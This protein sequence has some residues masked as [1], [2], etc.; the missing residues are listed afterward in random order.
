M[1]TYVCFNSTTLL[2][3][4]KTDSS[5]PSQHPYRHVS[6][7][8][9]QAQSRQASR[10]SQQKRELQVGGSS[11]YTALGTPAH[12]QTLSWSKRTCFASQATDAHTR[13]HAH[14]S[15]HSTLHRRLCSSRCRC[16]QDTHA[17]AP[18]S[19]H[20]AHCALQPPKSQR[21]GGVAVW[22]CRHRP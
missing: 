14:M 5:N 15:T 3:L 16:K 6:K 18:H 11:A 13:T 9:K 2:L 7:A 12:R 19:Q 8:G 21:R 22:V 1:Y 20:F 17:H 4:P 10:S